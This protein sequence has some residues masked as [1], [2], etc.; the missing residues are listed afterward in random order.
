MGGAA[1]FGAG[2]EPRGD[3]ARR[4]RREDHHIPSFDAPDG[5]PARQGRAAR[6]AARRP[7][8]CV[9]LPRSPGRL[10]A[11]RR[12]ALLDPRGTGGS[13]HPAAPA[14]YCC[15]RLADDAEAFRA[16]LG[17]ERMDALAHS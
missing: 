7:R 2:A 4:A 6:R 5:T 14:A 13:A 16:H 1:G 8:A 10:D 17:L 15:D 9:R 3:P 12:L 11:G